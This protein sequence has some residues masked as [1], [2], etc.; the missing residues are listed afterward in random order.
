MT[1]VYLALGSNVGDSAQYISKA[2]ELLGSSLHDIKQAPIYMSKAIGYTDQANYL[3][4]AI[5]G[6]TTL[7]PQELLTFIDNVEQEVGRVKRFH[8]GPREIDIDIIFYGEQVLKSEALT[9]PHPGFRERDFVLQPLIDLD[10]EIIDPISHKS[11][12]QLLEQLKP[13]Q[14]SI[15][16]RI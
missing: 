15:I 9:I 13:Q 11:L 16:N 12:K 14:L 2:I 7:S 3:N 8:W 10:D 1:T 6:Q 4:T 5:S